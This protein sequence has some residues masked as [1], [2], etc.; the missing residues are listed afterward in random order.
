MANQAAKVASAARKCDHSHHPMTLSQEHKKALAEG[1][2]QARAIKAYLRATQSR[3]T[4]RPVSRESLESRIAKVATQI[5]N[6]DDLKR[7]EL[8]QHRLDLESRLGE[9]SESADLEKLEAGFIEH[10]AA[11]SQRKGISYTAWRE[12]GVPAAVLKAAGIKET[13]RRS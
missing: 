8:I 11:Y 6:A 12:A 5:E 3:R 9:L 2:A 1:R 13:R 7:V 4:G 10:A